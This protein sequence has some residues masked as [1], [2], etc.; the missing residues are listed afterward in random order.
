MKYTEYLEKI[1]GFSFKTIEVYDKYAVMLEKHNLDYK[2]M[3]LNLPNYSQNTKRLIISSIISYYKF[4]NDER[5]KELTLPKKEVLVRDYVSFQEYKMFL[6]DINTQ[7]KT[8]QS[9]RLILRLLFETGIRSDEL[10]KIKVSDIVGNEIKI[11]GKGRRQRI[12]KVSEWLNEEL[13]SYIK[14]KDGRI[15][16]F[17]YKNLYSKIRAIGR[18]KKITPHMFRRGYAKYCFDNGISIYDISLSMGHS[19]IETTSRYISRNSKD[20]EIHKIF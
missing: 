20:V 3:L 17:Q 6:D 14:H 8:G 18:D 7:T 9:K 1:K 2:T 12:V 16:N 5:W 11:Y 19:S 13:N 10:L 4:L 15:F